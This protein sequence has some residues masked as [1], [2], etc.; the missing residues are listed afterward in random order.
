MYLASALVCWTTS[1]D[2]PLSNGALLLQRSSFAAA[3]SLDRSLQRI[4]KSDLK[5]QLTPRRSNLRMPPLSQPCLPAPRPHPLLQVHRSRTGLLPKNSSPSY[6]R[7]S[8]SH[9]YTPEPPRLLMQT[10]T[11]VC[12]RVHAQS[13]PTLCA[14]AA[15]FG[16]RQ[17]RP[18]R[19]PVFF[20][21]FAIGPRAEGSGPRQ[22]DRI[23]IREQEVP[24]REQDAGCAAVR[25]GSYPPSQ[26]LLGRRQAP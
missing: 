22:A 11:V 9:G 26:R 5:P 7:R 12:A 20:G 10:T 3:R 14:D 18:T 1:A 4:W 16:L 19:A 8:R 21:G 6:E 17:W 15:R 2:L 25:A 13:H 23:P 24:N